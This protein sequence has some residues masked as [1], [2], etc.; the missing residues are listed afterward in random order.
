MRQVAPLAFVIADAAFVTEAAPSLGARAAARPARPLSRRCPTADH[1]HRTADPG[2]VVLAKLRL[3]P[4]R[5]S[6]RR[7]HHS[8]TRLRRKVKMATSYQGPAAFRLAA[9][10]HCAEVP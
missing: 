6:G 3:K 1:G 8:S 5:G 7:A 4:T 2:L 9:A 10:V